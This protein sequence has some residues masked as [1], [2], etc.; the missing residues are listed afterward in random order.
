MNV[1]IGNWERGRAVSFLEIF[2]SNFRYS[3]FAVRFW[4]HRYVAAPPGKQVRLVYLH[5]SVWT[6]VGRVAGLQNVQLLFTEDGPGPAGGTSTL[7][8]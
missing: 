3:A 4:I 7:N 1:E 2:F 5:E 8:T 6:G